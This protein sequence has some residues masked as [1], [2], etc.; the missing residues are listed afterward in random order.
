MA[1]A[2]A[3]EIKGTVHGLR[4]YPRLPEDSQ[5]SWHANAEQVCRLVRAS[6]HPYKGAFSFVNGERII[7]WKARVFVP[8][9]KYLAIPGH[10]VEIRKATNT[11]LVACPDAMVELQEIE[12]NGKVMA[13]TE[14][15]K[16]I[17]VRL[18]GHPM[19]GFD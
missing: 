10:V 5:I 19:H 6:A 7:I 17:R 8:E 18:E 4:C 15:I 16:S 3:C 1:N 13:P 14:L 12:H 11:V 9:D 2:A